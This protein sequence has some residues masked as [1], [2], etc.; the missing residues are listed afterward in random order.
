MKSVFDSL[1]SMVSI[2]GVV[3][4]YANSKLQKTSKG[5]KTVCP[6]HIDKSKKQHL[7]IYKKYWKCY[8][9]GA[10]GDAVDFVQKLGGYQTKIQAIEQIV[11]DFNLDVNVD[12]FTPS[13]ETVREF[14]KVRKEYNDFVELEKKIFHNLTEDYKAFDEYLQRFTECDVEECG[15][16]WEA[17]A[18][19]GL[20]DWWTDIIIAGNY[21][22]DTYKESE[23]YKLIELLVTKYQYEVGQHFDSWLIGD[24]Y[25]PKKSKAPTAEGTIDSVESGESYQIEEEI[26]IEIEIQE[27]SDDDEVK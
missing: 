23:Q 4:K 9:C 5:Y 14:V 13:E 16:F 24:W 19:H 25:I 22:L 27:L 8:E 15:W 6:F 3:R 20:L 26:E 12:N 18:F 7:F 1:K 17:V 11:C 21:T 2:E 10:Y